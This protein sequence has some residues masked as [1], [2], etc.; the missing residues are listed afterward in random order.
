MTWISACNDIFL[1]VIT[2]E[3]IY[4]GLYHK[5]ALKQMAWLDKFLQLHCHIIPVT[6]SIAKQC[7]DLRGRF[8]GKGI[9]RSQ[10]DMLIA[11]TALRHQLTLVTRNERDFRKCGVPVLNPFL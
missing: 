11:A 7:G 6:E 8:I 3:E 9:V 1:S 4:C 10:A 2:V 5:E